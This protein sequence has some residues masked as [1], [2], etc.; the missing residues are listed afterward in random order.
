MKRCFLCKP[1]VKESPMSRSSDPLYEGKAK[2]IYPGP[3]ANQYIMYF[4]DDAT[5]FNAV[6]KDT[7]A[8][9]GILNQKIATLV[10]RYLQSQGIESH[11]LESLS[12]REMKVKAVDIVPLEVVVRNV[13]AGSL[14]KRLGLEEGIE[15][16]PPLVEFFYKKDALGDPLL[17]KQHI[18]MLNLC[19]LA[20]VQALEEKALAINNALLSLFD[21]ANIQLVDFKVEFGLDEQGQ[22]L[23]ADE[24]T[25]DGCRLWD[26]D[27]KKIL[28]KDRFR[29]DLGGLTQAY[30][31]VLQRIE[32]LV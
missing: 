13:A 4:K 17:T 3:A 14:C 32:T 12:D 27:S 6:K 30:E 11:F 15:I 20:Q 22:L 5:A 28:D 2:K 29:K 23:L 19:S 26:K 31:E 9:K 7:I 18:A 1:K 10:F 21:R 25:P 16:T 24:I 8:N